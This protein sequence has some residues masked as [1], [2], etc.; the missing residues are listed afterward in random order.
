MRDN[1][2]KKQIVFS[3]IIAAVVL[4]LWAP[5]LSKRVAVRRAEI[6]FTSAWQGTADGCGFNCQ[7]CGVVDARRVIGG[8]QVTLDYACG[9]VPEDATQYHQRDEGYVSGYGFVSGFRKP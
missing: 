2:M 4:L 6:A 7:G 3:L 5:W 1:P 9:L 8:W